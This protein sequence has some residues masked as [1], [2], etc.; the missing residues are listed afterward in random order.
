MG[1]NYWA[2]AR[3]I[4]IS[5]GVVTPPKFKK[6]EFTLWWMWCK[7]KDNVISAWPLTEIFFARA[8]LL[9]TTVAVRSGVVRWK[10]YFAHSYK[11]LLQRFYR[12]LEEM[13]RSSSRFRHD[14][15]FF[16]LTLQSEYTIRCITLRY[17]LAGWL[18][19]YF[20]FCIVLF[21]VTFRLTVTLIIAYKP[22][23]RIKFLRRTQLYTFPAISVQNP[24]VVY[25]LFQI[26]ADDILRISRFQTEVWFN[27]VILNNS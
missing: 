1:V 26:P 8:L 27:D 25:P 3:A 12:S 9:F 19:I 16:R 11:S 17:E 23:C 7:L 4:R 20:F 15:T 18:E 22:C 5:S 13:V 6:T 14:H 21:C 10:I 24:W 2:Y